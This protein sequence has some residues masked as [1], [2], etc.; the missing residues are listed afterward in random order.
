MDVLND[1]VAMK[2]MK[3][4]LTDEKTWQRGFVMLSLATMSCLVVLVLCGII[5]YQFMSILLS[6]KLNVVLLRLGKT[7]SSYMQHV[8]LYLTYNTDKRPFPF[9]RWP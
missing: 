1:S 9:M 2:A 3:K 6:G 5:L 8:L 7:L 4:H